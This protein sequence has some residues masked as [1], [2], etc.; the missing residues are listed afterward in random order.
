MRSPT[1]NYTPIK[2]A[3]L[4]DKMIVS[5]FILQHQAITR[6]VYDAIQS[7]AYKQKESADKH[8]R[9]NMSK[10]KK[11]DRVVLS[12]EGLRDTAV[13]KLGASKLAPRIN[14]PFRLLKVI[15]DAYTLDICSS[16]RL[17]PIFYVGL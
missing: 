14:G 10:F 5:E 15:D 2:F 9:K 13:S 7:A 16:L 3:R 11:G 17:H 6:F 8:S 1:A 4:I 12:N